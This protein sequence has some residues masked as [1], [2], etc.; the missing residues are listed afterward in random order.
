MF[1]RLAIVT[2]MVITLLSGCIFNA[3]TG[4]TFSPQTVSGSD[5]ALIYF[6]RPSS[7]SFGHDRTYFV[8]VNRR[9]VSDLLHRCYFPYGTSPEK[10][11]LL[12]DVNRSIRTMIGA[13][14]EV[15]ANP[16]AARLEMEVESGKIYYVQMH[17]ETSLTHF[18]PDLTLVTKEV[19]EKEITNWK[20]I[21]DK[22]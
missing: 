14:L 17:P 10:L 9:R 3:S 16:D 18:T 11:A 5:K 8:A 4:P 21:I 20:L 7:E 6:Y 15:I 1:I 12:S 2:S 22:Q 19:G 13:V